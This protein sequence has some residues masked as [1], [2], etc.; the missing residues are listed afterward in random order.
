ME[1]VNS[2]PKI[3]VLGAFIGGGAQADQVRTANRFTFNEIVAWSGSKHTL[4]GGINAADVSRQALDDKTNFHGTYT[5]ATLQDYRLDHPFSLLRQSGDGRVVFAEGAVAG[6]FQ[7]EFRVLPNLQIAAG[8]RYDWQNYFHDNN[9]FAPRLS[10]AFAP[11]K[12]KKTVIRAGGG[13]FYDRTGP[14]PIFDLIRYNGDRLHQYLITDPLPEPLPAAPANIV[15]LGPGV[16]MPY[17]LQYSAG[18]ERQLAKATTFYVTYTGIRGVHLFR[19]RD[20]NAPPPPFYSAR[21]DP[22]FN[23]IRQIESAGDMEGHSLEVGLR[24]NLTRYFNGMVEYGLGRTY[25]NNAGINSFPANNYDLSGEW[26]RAD[27]DSRHRFG[28]LGT[29]TLRRYFKLGAS[30]LLTS[31]S[32]YNET[33][34]RD[35]NRDGFANDRPAGVRRN[36]LQGPGYA[37]M[38]LRW[39][40]DFFLVAAKKDKGPTVTLS[41]DAFN[42][43]NRV[44]YTTYVGD[45]SS[46]FFGKPTAAQPPRRLQ[47]SFR[48]RF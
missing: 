45:L 3:V 26:S 33:T 19:S 2:E 10:F 13:L 28:L 29:L 18:V 31:G 6:F 27:F 17:T 34:G 22:R 43:L 15:R 12:S 16:R 1:S 9:N 14:G 41:F 35:D 46:P 11:G 40:R 39:S 48:F 42:L 32:P 20:V 8:L 5:F 24:G 7:D 38:D 47:A 36:S 23:V 37:Y 4:R 44:N 21:P 25:N 30:M